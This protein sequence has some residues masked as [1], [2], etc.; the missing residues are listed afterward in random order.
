MEY[1]IIFLL[2][3]FFIANCLSPT[4]LATPTLTLQHEDIQ[5]GETILATISTQGEFPSQIEKSQIKF[6]KGRKETTLEADILYYNSTHYIYIYT[7]QEE[8]I[9]LQ[10]ENILY[11]EENTLSSITLKKNLT[12]EKNLIFDEETNETYTEILK[13]KPG[14]IFTSNPPKF[15]ITNMGTRE[16][17]I[18]FNEEEISLLPFSTQEIENIPEETFSLTKISSYKDFLIPTVYLTGEENKT[19]I[20]PEIKPNLKA[21]PSLLFLELFTENS[22]KEI[23]QLFNFGDEN[24]TN[25]TIIHNTSFLKI[26]QPEDMLPRGIQNLTLELNPEISGHFQ[27][28]INISYT[29]QETQNL[30]EIPTS[31]FILPKG[32]PPENF[33]VKEETCAE[34]SGKV[35]AQGSFCNGTATFT[36]N[37]EYCCLDSCIETDSNKS[38]KSNFGWI[39]SLIIFA[40][41]IF[42]GYYFY[43]RQKEFKTQTPKDSI[44]ATTESFEKRLSGNQS[45]RTTG[46]LTKS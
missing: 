15:K 7:T 40:I 24:I 27:D 5:P 13:I 14:F 4:V 23:I 22:T 11:K 41:L 20:E 35:C 34:L 10:I 2:T 17:N 8:N 3:L 39:L 30:L 45:K 9:T 19:F 33:E 46:N 36:K 18:T 31:I 42:T 1:K 26:N 32:T 6:Y 12:I 38:E 37:S 29:Q 44:Q 43:K 16:F 25:I 28:S 21:N